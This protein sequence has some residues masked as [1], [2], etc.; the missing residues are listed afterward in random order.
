MNEH[1]NNCGCGCHGEEDLEMTVTLTL[2]ND[3]EVE[4]AVEVIFPVNGQEYIALVPLDGSSDGQAY[5]YRFKQLG[6][7]DMEI[8][9]IES[10][11]EFEMVADAYDELLDD[12]EF[13]ELI[14]DDEE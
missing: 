6:E 11:E 7:E 4:C 12:A 13:D 5:I 10:D 14:G 1:D 9:N 8:E 3:T 2:D